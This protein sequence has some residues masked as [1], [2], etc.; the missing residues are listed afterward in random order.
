M[1]AILQNVSFPWHISSLEFF[2][3]TNRL[4]SDN[5]QEQKIQFEIDPFTKCQTNFVNTRFNTRY[6]I[7]WFSYT[8]TLFEWS[9]MKIIKL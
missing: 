3:N 6:V 8:D 4:P 5:S 9:Q 2:W 1:S 7:P